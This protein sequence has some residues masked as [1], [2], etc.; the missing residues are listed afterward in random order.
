M[1]AGHRFVCNRVAT[2]E[3][4]REAQVLVAAFKNPR[5]KREGWEF[6]TSI[7]RRLQLTERD[8]AGKVLVHLDDEYGARRRQTDADWAVYCSL[9]AGW[10]HVFR[11]YWS[12]AWARMVPRTAGTQPWSPGRLNCSAQCGAL[13]KGLGTRVEWMPLGW[14]S[15]WSPSQDHEFRPS[16]S[17]LHFIGFY[18]NEKYQLKPNRGALIARF[19]RETGVKV[20][21]LL[22]R[23]GFGKG[24]LSQYQ[25]MMHNTQLCLQ[26]SG[27][28]AECYR[29][30]ESL[31]AGCVPVVIDQFG[32][33]TEAQYRYF[34]GNRRRNS[35]SP[36]FPHVSVPADLREELEKMRHNPMLL[37]AMQLTT[38]S[39]WNHSLEQIRGRLQH[40]AWSWCES[41]GQ[42][43]GRLRSR[44]ASVR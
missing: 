32:H 26:I 6:T 19:E 25:H 8:V 38:R 15:N 4:V 13:G 14:S 34:L 12:E 39:W 33:E 43:A 21:R 36:P 22:G 16:T 20:T 28:S 24:N 5:E 1:F 9:Y 40:V 42:S 23:V 17:R 30:Y 2:A 11:N 41:R 35:L 7:L 18:G 27:L 10:K 3:D 29:M 44:A 31:D 37:G